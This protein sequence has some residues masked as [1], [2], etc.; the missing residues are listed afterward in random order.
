MR[1][2]LE[3]L[4]VLR[5]PLAAKWTDFRIEGKELMLGAPFYLGFDRR[6]R[7]K[8]LGVDRH[9]WPPDKSLRRVPPEAAPPVAALMPEIASGLSASSGDGAAAEGCCPSD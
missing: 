1:A 9:C 8:T 7:W 6:A 3:K 5:I 4:Q 2:R